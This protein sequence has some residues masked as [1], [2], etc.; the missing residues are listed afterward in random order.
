MTQRTSA[1]AT[2]VYLIA[3]AVKIYQLYF[4]HFTELKVFE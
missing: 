2:P 4:I 1:R 3:V